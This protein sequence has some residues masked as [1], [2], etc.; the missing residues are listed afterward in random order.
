MTNYNYYSFCPELWNQFEIE[1]NGD[2]KICCLA[3][4]DETGGYGMIRD[5]NGNVM[6]A[7]THTAQEA[8]NSPSMRNHR[9]QLS[10]NE[11]PTLCR[12]CYDVEDAT[13]GNSIN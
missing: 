7:G 12:N 4:N 11:R 9:L 8:L 1:A 10:R 2:Y 5:E 3:N 6:N 13:Y